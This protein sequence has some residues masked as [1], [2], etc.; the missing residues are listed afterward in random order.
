MTSLLSWAFSLAFVIRPLQ[1]FTS[2]LCKP[3]QLTA[4]HL[5]SFKLGTLAEEN[6]FV[7][8]ENGVA[9]LTLTV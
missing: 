9:E 8:N 3:C 1:N 5:P 2:Q 7:H 4:R 6:A